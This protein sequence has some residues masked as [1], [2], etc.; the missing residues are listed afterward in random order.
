MIDER[1]EH[2]SEFHWIDP[3]PPTDDEDRAWLLAREGV[4][5]ASGRAALRALVEHGGWPRVWLPS[6]VCG[7]VADAV[8]DRLRWYDDD[9]T[10]PEPAAIEAAAGDALV[11]IDYFGLRGPSSAAPLRER[12]VIVIDDHTHDP[13]GPWA[14]RSDADYCLVSLRKSLPLPDGALTWS[15]LGHPL[16]PALP[17]S[18]AASTKLPAMLLKSL[19]LAGHPVAKPSFRALAIAGERQLGELGVVGMSS[20]S[21]EL[22]SCLAIARLRAR[23]RENFAAFSQALGDRVELLRPSGSDNTPFSCVL[24]L[25]DAEARERMRAKLIDARIYPAVLWPLD[26][27][28]AHRDR[29]PTSCSFAERMLAL[30]CDAR[31]QVDDMRRVA[32]VVVG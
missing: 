7:E 19:Y 18:E 17:A 2:G 23:R 5:H 6:Y 10:R 9:P 11:R 25:P 15:A 1:W 22:F 26:F 24:V 31:Y 21:W 3:G 13:C 27:G 28:S 30:H 12:G 8:G 20:V 29:F 32:A 14:R 16:P 4:T